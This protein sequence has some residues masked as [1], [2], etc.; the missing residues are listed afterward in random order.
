[1]PIETTKRLREKL[2][3]TDVFLMYGLTE[4]FRSTY[5]PPDLVDS[6]PDS[7]GRAIPNADVIVVRPDGE[8]CGVDEPGELVHRGA[9]VSLGY[10]GDKKKTDIRFRPVPGQPRQIPKSELAVWSGDKVKRDADGFLYFLGRDDEMIKSS[11]YRISPSEIEEVAYQLEGI[12][13]AVA[14]G[15][16]HPELGQAIVLSVEADSSKIDEELILA[17][18]R[19]H[20]PSFMLPALI[21]IYDKLPRNPNGKL[22]RQLL[23][24]GFQDAFI[25]QTENP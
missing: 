11:G 5:L 6:R 18:C 4:A 19:P 10:W 24:S 8:I 16:A 17:H 3:N 12:R 25:K 1:M 21:R 13:Q 23:S 15:V 14:F 7:I 22:D 9:L 2:P 20:L